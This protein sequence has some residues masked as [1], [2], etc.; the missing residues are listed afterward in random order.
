ML[1]F[2][3]Q[4]LIIINKDLAECKD[5]TSKTRSFGYSTLIYFC[6]I[7][8]YITSCHFVICF[9][10][11]MPLNFQ[12]YSIILFLSVKTDI[13]PAH[14]VSKSSRSDA[15]FNRRINKYAHSFPII[16]RLTSLC[17]RTIP[18][19]LALSLILP[20]LCQCK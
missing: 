1:N 18:L 12:Q 7:H 2:M 5:M 16:W 19:P 20:L 14:A 10:R 17:F 4:T 13:P 11:T 9:S 15:F 3:I 6:A 8:F